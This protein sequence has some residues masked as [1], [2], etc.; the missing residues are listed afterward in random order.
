MYKL[1]QTE[2]SMRNTLRD[3]ITIEMVFLFFILCVYV[4]VKALPLFLWCTTLIFF[5]S[6]WFSEWKRRRLSCK[7]VVGKKGIWWLHRRQKA[8]EDMVVATEEVGGG[9]AMEKDLGVFLLL[10]FLYFSNYLLIFYS[11]KTTS[12]NCL[13]IFYLKEFASANIDRDLTVWTSSI[14]F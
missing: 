13:F 1:K 3:V 11:K 10:L 7:R 9:V 2:F 8:V 12:A 6:F 5:F 4:C 14:N